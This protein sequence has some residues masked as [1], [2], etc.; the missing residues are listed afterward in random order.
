MSVLDPL[1]AKVSQLE[2]DVMPGS[3]TGSRVLRATRSDGTLAL[4]VGTCE[5]ATE[6]GF[7]RFTRGQRVAR[8]ITREEYERRFELWNR[9]RIP[10]HERVRATLLGQR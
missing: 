8:A 3:E 2:V 10:A 4:E 7:L 1:A 9:P 5:G 6:L